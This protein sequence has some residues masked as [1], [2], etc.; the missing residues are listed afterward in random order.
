[1]IYQYEIDFS[2]MYK[3]KVTTIQ[4]TTVQANSLEFAKEKL[5]TETKRRLGNCEILF[6][7]A[8]LQVSEDEKYNIVI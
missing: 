6:H 4:S 8:S 3:D 2:V 5:E 7:S 1:M